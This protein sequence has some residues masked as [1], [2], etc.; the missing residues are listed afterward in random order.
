MESVKL[1]LKHGSDA[2]IKNDLGDDAL[3]VD[4]LCE[5]TFIKWK[6]L[7]LHMFALS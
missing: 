6:M 7:T 2:Y 5:K 4:S 3:Q 1:L